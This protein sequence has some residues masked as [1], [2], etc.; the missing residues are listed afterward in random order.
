MYLMK[1]HILVLASFLCGGAVFAQ[2]KAPA[3]KANEKYAVAK[4]GTFASFEST[5]AYGKVTLTKLLTKNSSG[6]FSTAYFL[7]NNVTPSFNNG[8]PFEVQLG[9]ESFDAF[10]QKSSPELSQKWTQLVKFAQ[11]KKLSFSDE[12]TWSDVLNYFNSLK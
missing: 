4:E 7:K 5:L 9:K 12:Q 3:V 2:D 8:K 6:A 10:F 11:D 1:K